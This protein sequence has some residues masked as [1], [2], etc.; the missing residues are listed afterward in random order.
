MKQDIE[1]ARYLATLRRLSTLE[2][3]VRTLLS[4]TECAAF[5]ARLTEIAKAFDA[6]EQH[7]RL[8]LHKPINTT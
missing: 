4:P 3:T 8:D 1:E 5:D 6:P 2:E 7:P